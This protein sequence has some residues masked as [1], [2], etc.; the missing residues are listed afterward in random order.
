M[1]PKLGASGTPVNTGPTVGVN[2]SDRNSTGVDDVLEATPSSKSQV[3]RGGQSPQPSN[4][5]SNGGPTAD[6]RNAGTNGDNGHGGEES[7]ATSSQLQTNIG[8][9][10]L[11][12]PGTSR[13]DRAQED[14]SRDDGVGKMGKQETSER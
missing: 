4:T 12:A 14:D 13:N 1:A 3:L 2:T 9:L 5:P 8:S 10:H 6:D 11:T 7:N